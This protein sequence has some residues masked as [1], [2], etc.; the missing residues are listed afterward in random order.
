MRISDWSSDVCAS[1]LHLLQVRECCSPRKL[2]SR[3]PIFRAIGDAEYL[4]PL[5]LLFD[6]CGRHAEHRSDMRAIEHSTGPFRHFLTKLRSPLASCPE[7]G[8]AHV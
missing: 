4:P 6:G 8:R 5:A 2:S 3:V 7:I 1:D